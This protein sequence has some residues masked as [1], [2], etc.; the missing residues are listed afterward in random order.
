MRVFARNRGDRAQN[1]READ[2]K[3]AFFASRK[4]PAAEIKRA[5]RG[6]VE[7]A[8]QR[9]KIVGDELNLFELLGGRG[10]GFAELRKGVH[11]PRVVKVR[12]KFSIARA[13]IAVAEGG[14]IGLAWRAGIPQDA[15][16]KRFNIWPE[17]I[18]LGRTVCR[19]AIAE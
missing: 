8:V 13:V 15:A 14:K 7:I 9:P 11:G 6:I 5:E 12:S 16:F 17:A 18:G 10:D 1:H 3:N 4:N 2:R 19:E